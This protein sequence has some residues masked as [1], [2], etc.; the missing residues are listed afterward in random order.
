VWNHKDLKTMETNFDSKYGI[1]FSVFVTI[2][3]FYETN[4]TFECIT[5]IVRIKY[6]QQQMTAISNDKLFA[7]V[8]ISVSHEKNIGKYKQPNMSNPTST[9]PAETIY[10]RLP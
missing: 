5:T 8:Y 4:K 10:A 1:H 2:K 3:V 7:H 9:N 6:V